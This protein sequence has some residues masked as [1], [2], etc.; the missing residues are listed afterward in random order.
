MSKITEKLESYLSG[1]EWRRHAFNAIDAIPYGHVATYGFIAKQV[2]S[3]TGTN[4]GPRNIGE[5]RRT[6]Y[7]ILTHDTALPLHRVAKQGDAQSNYDSEET[8]KI[9]TQR[10][11]DEGFFDNQR[12][13]K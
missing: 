7:G 11:D 1:A 2:E 3:Q 13:L 6:L 8:K 10:R 4:P 5:L 9:N 12:W